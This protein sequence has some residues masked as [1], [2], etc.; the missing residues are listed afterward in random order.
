MN[1]R[2]KQNNGS[3]TVEACFVVPLFLFWMLALGEMAMLFLANAHIYQCLADAA[4]Y[5]AR[6]GYLQERLLSSSDGAAT[7]V[8]NQVEVAA[9]FHRSLQEDIY[10]EKTVYN[11]ENGILLLVEPDSENA[12]I[13]TARVSYVARISIPLLGEYHRS[14]TESVRQKSFVGYHREEKGEVYVYVTPNQAVYHVRSSCTYLTLQTVTYASSARGSYRACAFCGKEKNNTGRIY[15]SQSTGTFHYRA[16]C[17]GLKRT[18]QRVRLSQVGGLG[19]C[20]RCG[21]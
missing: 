5:G 6:Q 17:S 9:Q 10:I 20:S 18:V 15:V 21:R 13:F 11:G 2:G 19:P 4:E 7:S 14:I 8:V 12:R 16:D 3:A 1:H